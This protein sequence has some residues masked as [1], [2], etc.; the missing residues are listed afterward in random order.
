M[1]IVVP[2]LCIL[3]VTSPSTWWSVGGA[4]LWQ[5]DTKGGDN[6]EVWSD[7]GGYFTKVKKMVDGRT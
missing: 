6:G 4:L 2:L 3:C 5:I 7:K 1:V